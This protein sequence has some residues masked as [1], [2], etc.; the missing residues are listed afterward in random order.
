[1]PPPQKRPDSVRQLISHEVL[2]AG[3]LYNTV[4]WRDADMAV[5]GHSFQ[6]CEFEDYGNNFLF[7]T[8]WR[9]TLDLLV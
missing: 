7:L 6:H 8:F 1:M 9:L 4:W 3:F 5:T 2:T